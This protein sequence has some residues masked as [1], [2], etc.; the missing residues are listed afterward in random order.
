MPFRSSCTG[1]TRTLEPEALPSLICRIAPYL[2]NMSYIYAHAKVRRW[3][4]TTRSRTSKAR[5]SSDVI[6]KGKF[7][8]HKQNQGR[9]R[10]AVQ[11]GLRA[12][13][14]DIQHAVDLR[15]Q[16]CVARAPSRPPRVHLG[17]TACL[18]MELAGQGGGAVPASGA[19]TCI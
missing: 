9:R 16:P 4:A 13:A 14:P 1:S 2:P 17:K 11:R 5:T 12:G 6:L 3:Q 18:T 10:H 7:L 15:R 19:I 8:E